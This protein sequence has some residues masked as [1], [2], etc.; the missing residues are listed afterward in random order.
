ME[1]LGQFLRQ[2]REKHHLSIEEVAARTRIRLQYVQ[3]MEENRFDQLPHQVSAKGFLRCYA[4]ALGLDGGDVLQR[5]MALQPPDTAPT[6]FTEEKPAPAY[7]HVKR[8]GSLPFYF[9]ITAWIVG[10]LL[11]AGIAF[12]MSGKASVLY[13]PPPSPRASTP[14]ATVAEPVVEPTI[15]TAIEVAQPLPPVTVTEAAPPP[16][17]ESAEPPPEAAAVPAPPAPAPQTGDPSGALTLDLEAVEP[18][19]V[20]VVIDGAQTDDVLLQAGQKM[21]WRARHGFLLTLGNAGGV[22]VYL[23]GQDM[24]PVGARGRVVRD[25]RLP[26]E[27]R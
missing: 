21:A 12:W 19:W 25:I 11:L 1:N 20:R 8:V 5:F 3:A 9:R 14:E 23:N 22:R 7:I 18:S 17:D 24:G 6:V 15:E 4:S 26:P 27:V 2:Q 10:A 16:A 13:R